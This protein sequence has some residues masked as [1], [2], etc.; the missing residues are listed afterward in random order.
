MHTAMVAAA[1]AALVVTAG[2]AVSGSQPEEGTEVNRTNLT[3]TSSGLA[4]PASAQGLSTC[5]THYTPYVQTDR[6]SLR[7]RS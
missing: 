3:C 4:Y 5:A 6:R 2:A 7:D 1:V